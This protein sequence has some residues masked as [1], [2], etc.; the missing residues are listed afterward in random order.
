MNLMRKLSLVMVMLCAISVQA[1]QNI[2]TLGFEQAIGAALNNDVWQQG[3]EHKRKA[4]LAQSNVVGTLP[5]PVMS[6][7]VVNIASDSFAFN[8]EP[9]SQ[10]KLGIAQKF[11]RG[12]SLELSKQQLIE[13]SLQYPMLALER[14]AKLR[15]A[16]GEVWLRAYQAQQTMALIAKDRPLFEQ[17]IDLAQRSYQV[18]QGR[19]MQ[20]D[21]IS[22]EVELTSID[23]RLAKLEIQ[24]QRYQQQLSRWLPEQFVAI[25]LSQDKP[26]FNM[27]NSAKDSSE[28]AWASLLAKHPSVMVLNAQQKALNTGIVLARQSQKVQWG[29]SSS[30]GWRSNSPNGD[31]RADLISVGV[32]FDL[33]IFSQN[34]NRQQISAAKAN[35]Q[36]ANTDKLLLIRQMR[37]NALA[38]QASLK[39]LQ[40]REDLYNNKLLPQT[41]QHSQ[42]ALTAY[43]NDNG[44]FSRVV[45]ARVN[46]LNQRIEAFNISIEKQITMLKLNYYLTQVTNVGAVYE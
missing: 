42:A 35:A 20:S 44:E 39:L 45:L 10:L 38:L 23:D 17:L 37:G 7:G 34:K 41:R 26:T 32:S 8:Q 15:V 3:N 22:A 31:S 40:R 30:Y 24:A 1:Q 11:A 18:G 27:L 9:M 33:P 12:D 21:L 19:T 46:E 14:Q 43:G 36:V 6:L 29:V 16:V 28:A 5:D 13:Q 2:D 25:P 4:M